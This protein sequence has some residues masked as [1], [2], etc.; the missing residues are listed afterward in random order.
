MLH[1]IKSALRHPEIKL[2]AASWLFQKYVLRRDPVRLLHNIPL[3]SFVDFSEFHS[4]TSLVSK[5]EYDFLRKH[6]FGDGAVLDIGA[7]LG[8]FSL[9]V[10]GR[11]NDRRILAFEPGP[12]TFPALKD[13]IARNGAKVECRR[14]ALAD[15]DGEIRFAMMEKARANSKITTDADGVAVP[16]RRLDS[17][18]E[19]E[20]ITQIALLKID[21]EGFEAAVLRGAPRTLAE[22]RPAVIYF[23]ICPALAE[24]A[25][26]AADEA[27]RIIQDAGYDLFEFSESGC[28]KPVTPEQIKSINLANWLATPRAV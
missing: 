14:L 9:V 16:V 13:N 11:Y 3:S 12:S 28:V 10:A 26:F 17:I 2:E 4:A 8:M 7:N 23:E 24:L 25:G 1:L 15:K 6:D 5:A 22:I 21:T 20:G 27:A 19:E 18:V